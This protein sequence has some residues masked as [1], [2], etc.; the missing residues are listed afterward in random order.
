MISPEPNRSGRRE[1]TNQLQSPLA[2][3]VEEGKYTTAVSS[4]L[5]VSPVCVWMCVCVFGGGEEKHEKR[6]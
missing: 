3:D 1:L 4:S 5:P 6:F 2:F